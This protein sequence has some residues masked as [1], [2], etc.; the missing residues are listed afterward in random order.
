MKSK[1][2]I[3]GDLKPENIL[4]SSNTQGNFDL[5]IADFGFSVK[6]NRE[7]VKTNEI[8][9]TPGYIAPEIL[10]RCL[11]SHKSDIFSIGSIMYNLLTRKNL[12][13]GKDIN[14][15][16]AKNEKCDL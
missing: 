5:R 9:G 16:L 8:L 1:T 15:I 14:E 2:I 7:Y 3:H 12:F 13:K 10:A 4:L 11:Y 6:I